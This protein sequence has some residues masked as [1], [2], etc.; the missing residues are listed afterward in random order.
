[1]RDQLP[2]LQKSAKAAQDSADAAKTA[3]TQARDNFRQEQR[4]YNWLTN[5]L[6][7]PT[8]FAPSAAVPLGQDQNQKGYVVWDWHYTNYGKSPTQNMHFNHLTAM[9]VI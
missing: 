7:G 1:M 5:N 8:F 3:I 9:S 2:E 4:P 6:G